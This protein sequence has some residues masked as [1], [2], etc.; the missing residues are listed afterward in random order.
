MLMLEISFPAHLPQTAAAEA[1]NWPVFI[2]LLIQVNG[3]IN[4]EE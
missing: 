3:L 2:N 4:K 1:D